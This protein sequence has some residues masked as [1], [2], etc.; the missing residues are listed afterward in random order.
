MVRY[1][2]YRG[3]LSQVHTWQQSELSAADYSAITWCSS[4]CSDY[5]NSMYNTCKIHKQLADCTIS[6]LINDYDEL[7]GAKF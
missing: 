4:M 2:L 3:G 1:M 5:I 6:W 7:K